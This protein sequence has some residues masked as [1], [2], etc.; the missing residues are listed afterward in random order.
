MTSRVAFPRFHFSSERG[1]SRVIVRLIA[2]PSS[3]VV[4]DDR[5]MTNAR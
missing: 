5:K 4:R 3:R 2:E 1:S